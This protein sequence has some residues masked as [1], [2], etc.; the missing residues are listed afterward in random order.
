MS[1]SLNKMLLFVSLIACLAFGQDESDFRHEME[2]EIP[3][4]IYDC[5]V[6]PIAERDSV[7]IDIV[8]QVPFNTIQ[9]IKKD[10]IFIGKYEISLMLLDEKEVNVISKIWTQTLKTGNFSETYS[11]EIFDV[12]KLN[13]KI[14]PSKYILTIG[15]LDLDTRKSTFRKKQID[16][17]DFYKKPITLSNINLIESSLADSS[18]ES[19]DISSIS[20]RLVDQRSEFDVS[21]YLLSNGG[22][23]TIKYMIYNMNKKVVAEDET[24]HVFKKGVDYHKMSIP[25]TNLTYSKYR[26]VIKVKLGADEATA[27]KIIQI[28]WIGM[29]NMIDNLDLAIEQIK[30]IAGSNILK[31]MKKADEKEKKDLFLDFWN[32]KDP[33]PGTDENELMNEYYRRVNYSNQN[34]SGYQDGWKTDMGMVFILFGAPNDIERHPFELQ[35]KP[36]EIWYYYELNRT[37]VFVDET[38]FGEYRLITPFDYYGSMY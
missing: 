35:T 6:T 8:I 27:E 26:L 33:T 11:A 20:G 7:S 5:A 32:K 24:T 18:G 1:L 29:S 28:R 30:Y 34:F 19:S 37:F 12:S 21:F 16:L 9:F 4:F 36:Y 22:S 3:Y 14:A 23:G 2:P 25:R 38:G 10:S 17:D 31:K 15:V 13:Y